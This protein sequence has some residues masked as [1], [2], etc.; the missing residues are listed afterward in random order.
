[1]KQLS[2]DRMKI[3]FEKLSKYI[4]TNIKLLIDRSDGKYCFREKKD[5]VYYVSEK[6]LNM[7][8]MM[9]PDN[10]IS[11]GTCFGKFTKSGKFRLHITALDY[12]SP[13]AQHK[14]WVK[15]AAEQQFVYG[16]NILKSGLGRITESTLQYQGVIIFSMSDVPLG[17]G[18][19]AKGT[20]ECKHT[21]PLSVVCFNQADIGEF[22]RCEDDLI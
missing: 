13:Y 10:I 11:I 21:D 8:S 4:G 7:G 5:R 14:M 16:H 19:A 3:F 22:I 1:M 12:L 18:V 2:D 15:P 17:F 9:N 20:T 6:V